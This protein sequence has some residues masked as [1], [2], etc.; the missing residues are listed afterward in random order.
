MI[1]DGK[2]QLN[3]YNHPF[4]IRLNRLIVC[5]KGWYAGLGKEELS[6]DGWDCLKYPK[7]G[8]EQKRGEGKQRF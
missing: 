4:D 5:K 3:W 8:F 2:R 1:F 7:R 6:E